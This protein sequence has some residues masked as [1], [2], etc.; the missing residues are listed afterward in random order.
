MK[1]VAIGIKRKGESRFKIS[2]ER[3]VIVEAL[4]E[5]NGMTTED[6]EFEIDLNDWLNK[7]NTITA[8]YA[9]IINNTPTR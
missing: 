6:A 7:Q 5:R 3:K 9:S 4:K 1:L 2:A 8:N